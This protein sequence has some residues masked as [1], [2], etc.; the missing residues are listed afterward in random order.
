MLRSEFETEDCHL[1]LERACEEIC[2]LY[3]TYGLEKDNNLN[4]DAKV[5]KHQIIKVVNIIQKLPIPCT[6][7]RCTGL[8]NIESYY[9]KDEE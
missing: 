2:F 8:P 6:C 1:N 5:L 3:K 9:K 4:E 7:S